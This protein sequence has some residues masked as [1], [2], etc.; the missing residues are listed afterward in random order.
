MK[1][2][3]HLSRLSGVVT[4][5]ETTEPAT[6]TDVWQDKAY[7]AFETIIINCEPE[8]QILI[9]GCD[10]PAEAWKMLQEHYEGRT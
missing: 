4:R 9:E 3:L 10:T 1:Q 8:A 5:T 2:I 7:K 6:Q